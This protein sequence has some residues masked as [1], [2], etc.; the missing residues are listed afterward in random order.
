[1][2][3]G[4]MAIIEDPTGAIVAFRQPSEAPAKKKTAR[5]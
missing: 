2:E 4:A 3:F 1:M 5:K